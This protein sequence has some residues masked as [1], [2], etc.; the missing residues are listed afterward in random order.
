MPRILGIVK[1]AESFVLQLGYLIFSIIELI[2]TLCRT[3][4]RVNKA[5]LANRREL[6]FFEPEIILAQSANRWCWQIL[7]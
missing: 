1:A 7:R 4:P 6:N 5:L 3:E 2:Q